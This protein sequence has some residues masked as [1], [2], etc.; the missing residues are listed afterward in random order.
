[1]AAKKKIN[2]DE[3]NLIEAIKIIAQNKF[4]ILTIIIILLISILG[5][6]YSKIT[7]EIFKVSVD[8]SVLYH[9]SRVE[10]LCGT[11][12]KCKKQNTTKEVIRAIGSD[13]NYDIDAEKLYIITTSP[14]EADDYFKIFDNHNQFL[15][16][17]IY[18]STVN[19]IKNL[20]L[21]ENVTLGN[22]LSEIYKLKSEL[23]NYVK[24]RKGRT[25]NMIKKSDYLMFIY[26]LYKNSDCLKDL[27]QFSKY[28]FHVDKEVLNIYSKKWD[29]YPTEEVRPYWDGRR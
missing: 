8:F 18:N 16:D 29:E 26:A 12:V 21:F 5:L 13:W 15:T 2:N 7:A 4:Q 10:K 20:E 3:I 22:G 28:L 17:E 27:I 24:D 11:N 25:I 9:T 1:M 23:L 14:L 6:N 19:D